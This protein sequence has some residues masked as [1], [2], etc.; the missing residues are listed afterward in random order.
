MQIQHKIDKLGLSMR[1]SPCV[2]FAKSHNNFKL[3]L[4]CV[5]DSVGVNRSNNYSI[6]SLY[7]AQ[8]GHYDGVKLAL[9]RA[10]LTTVDRW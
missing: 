9:G 4:N 7:S 10:R 8:T 5:D 3:S 1:D 2:K 6:Y